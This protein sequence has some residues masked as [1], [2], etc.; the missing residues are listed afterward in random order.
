M[1]DVPPS[2]PLRLAAAY[3]APPAAPHARTG[4]FGT[5]NSAGKPTSGGDAAFTLKAGNNHGPAMDTGA[6]AKLSRLVAARI[7]PASTPT[8]GPLRA[9][10]IEST[11]AVAASG[12]P[13]ASSGI[14]SKPLAQGFDDPLRPLQMYRNPADRNSAATDVEAGRRIDLQ[15]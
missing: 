10:K 6:S 1:S 3:A 14:E 15:A 11:P 13:G 7:T 2:M 4:Q 12:R 8:P 9:T 5:G